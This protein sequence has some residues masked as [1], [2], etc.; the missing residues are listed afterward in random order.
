MSLTLYQQESFLRGKGGITFVSQTHSTFA[1]S[2]GFLYDGKKAVA[3]LLFLLLG[4]F[5]KVLVSEVATGNHNKTISFLR[6]LEIIRMYIHIHTC[7]VYVC[8]QVY[9][10]IT[11]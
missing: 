8:E 11:F 10:Y 4:K 2:A 6:N 1:G 9:L 7:I 5:D 3:S